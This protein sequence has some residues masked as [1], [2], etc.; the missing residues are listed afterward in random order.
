MV[1]LPP[2]TKTVERKRP[3]PAAT[4]KPVISTSSA[5]PEHFDPF[6]DTVKSKPTVE[7][8]GALFAKPGNSKNFQVCIHNE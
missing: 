8:D 4:R 2:P 3:T 5:F 6:S 1:A 7:T